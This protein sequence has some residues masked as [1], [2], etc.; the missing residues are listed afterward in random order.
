MSLLNI[1]N[2]TSKTMDCGHN[3][4]FNMLAY[5]FSYLYHLRVSF[6][7]LTLPIPITGCIFLLLRLPGNFFIGY[8]AL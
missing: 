4:S 1:G 8:Q 5:L 2:L 7:E 3:N 6:N